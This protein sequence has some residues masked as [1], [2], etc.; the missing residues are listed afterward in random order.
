[1]NGGSFLDTNILVYAHHSGDRRKQHIAQ[2]LLLDAVAGGAVISTQVLSELTASLLHKLTPRVGAKA[3]REI[4]IL[5][6]PI[7]TITI[8]AAAVGRALDTHA[9]YGLH[10]YDGLIVAA[11]ERAG[12]S[13]IL[14]EDMNADQ[15]YFGVKVENPFA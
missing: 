13:R 4:L 15:V 8:D 9:R 10:F 3:V 11:A 1:M 12:C 6:E 7:R 2:Q 14:S 5:L